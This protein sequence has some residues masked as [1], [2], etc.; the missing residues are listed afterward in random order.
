MTL[1]SKLSKQRFYPCKLDCGNFFLFHHFTIRFSCKQRRAY[2]RNCMI[3]QEPVVS[4]YTSALVYAISRYLTLASYRILC[5]S[6][7]IL[8]LHDEQFPDE[9]L[10][11]CET[12]KMLSGQSQGV[13]SRD[14]TCVVGLSSI[15]DNNHSRQSCC[16]NYFD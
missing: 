5:R 13:D 7:N 8:L 11:P 14:I 16:R 2:I 12:T 1:I 4:I 9:L 3:Q 6:L 15:R 10:P